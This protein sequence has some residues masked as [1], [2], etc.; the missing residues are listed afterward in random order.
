MRRAVATLIKGTKVG[1]VYQDQKS[2]DVVVIGVPQLRT[3]LAALRRLQ[4]DLPLG[5]H[6]PLGDVADVEIVPA[7]NEI[8]RENASAPPWT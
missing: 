4:I 5:G 2:F 1:E 8:K 6:A 3:D 7:P